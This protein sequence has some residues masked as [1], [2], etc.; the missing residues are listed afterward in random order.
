[1]RRIL[2]FLFIKR[3]KKRV[4]KRTYTSGGYKN[5]I[6]FIINAPIKEWRDRLWLVENITDYMGECCIDEDIFRWLTLR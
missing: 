1:M 6:S 4:L 5:A 3:I 2:L